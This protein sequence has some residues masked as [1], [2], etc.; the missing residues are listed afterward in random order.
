[1]SICS[2]KHFQWGKLYN[3]ATTR[4]G[5]DFDIVAQSPDLANY[6]SEIR[7]IPRRFAV[8]PRNIETFPGAYGWYRWRDGTYI[9]G[10]FQRSPTVEYQD[11]PHYF[12][13]AHYILIPNE[14]VD[15]LLGDLFPFFVLLQDIPRRSK[16]TAL[17]PVV[18]DLDEL[19]AEC[20]TRLSDYIIPY[21]PLVFNNSEVV[22]RDKGKTPNERLQILAQLAAC[23]PPKFRITL[24]CITF[25]DP[26]S[27]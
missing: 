12:V 11:R 7:F 22:F 17:E 23:F 8:T 24:P 25:S 2:F 18:V 1:M 10:H 26:S 15:H 27:S 9:I 5:S 21:I 13:Q 6:I 14:V 20:I 19:K 16:M 3:E 4:V